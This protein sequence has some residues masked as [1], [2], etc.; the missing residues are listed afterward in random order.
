FGIAPL[1]AMASGLPLLAPN[2]GGLTSYASAANAWTVPPTVG[3]F[4]EAVYEVMDNR[5]LV[6]Q[7]K[8][9]ALATAATYSWDRVADGFLDLYQEMHD[10]FHGKTPTAPADFYSLPAA[11]ATARIATW[12][13]QLAQKIFATTARW[14]ES[15]ASNSRDARY[16]TPFHK[17]NLGKS[18]RLTT[19]T[20][21]S[22]GGEASPK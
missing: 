7:K 4:A 6:A 15:A 20:L 3:H 21:P 14:R 9:Q 2:S 1:E 10:C 19:N 8:Q 16:T 5:E 17:A 18:D 11:R 12:T 13:A 22:D